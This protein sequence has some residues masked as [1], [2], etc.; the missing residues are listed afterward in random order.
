MADVTRNDIE[1]AARRIAGHVRRTP[2]MAARFPGL[3]RPVEMKLEHL[4]LSGSFKA[5][6]AF[7]TL[8]AGPVPA[9]GL[10]AASGGNHGAHLCAGTGRGF[11]DRPDRTAGRRP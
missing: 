1:T 4:Q 11:Q 9:A 5:R 2:V 10:V 3:D 7:N 8:L 6:G